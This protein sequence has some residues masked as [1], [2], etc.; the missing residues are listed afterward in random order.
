MHL[1]HVD[2]KLEE[3]LFARIAEDYRG[4]L[5]GLSRESDRL[6]EADHA[7]IE[8]GI[9]LLGIAKDARR[10]LAEADFA[11][12]RNILHHLLSNCSYSDGGVSAAFHK[13]FDI[14]VESLPKAEAREGASSAII[15]E[16]KKWLPG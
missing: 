13:P 8:D 9:A 1:D 3:A 15:G 5:K 4:D 6:S 7:D 10:K 12:K 14:I 16:N 2:G 11:G